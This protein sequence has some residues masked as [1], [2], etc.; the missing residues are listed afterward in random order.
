V[1]ALRARLGAGLSVTIARSSVRLHGAVL[2]RNLEPFVAL[3]ARLV[4]EPALRGDDLSRAKRRIIDELRMLR[5]DDHGLAD[6]HLRALL[7]GDHAYGQPVGGTG[8][9]LRAIRRADV[10]EQHNSM[11]RRGALVFG[12]AG[13]LRAE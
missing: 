7:F 1:A 5:E 9:S 11:V 13:A 12:A 8:A 10:L 4:R 3:V 6:R 2:A